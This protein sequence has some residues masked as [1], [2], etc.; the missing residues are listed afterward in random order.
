MPEKWT[1]VLLCDM[2]LARV[3]AKEL[4]D[5]VGWHPKYLSVVLN[6]HRTPKGAEKQ[7]RAAFER[8]V[9]KRNAEQKAV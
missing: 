5:E 1:G 3:T 2:H 6:G 4:A 9:S 8:I 7:L